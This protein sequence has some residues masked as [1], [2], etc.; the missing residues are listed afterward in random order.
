[1]A[2]DEAVDGK[3]RKDQ[4]LEA[5]EA[6]TPPGGSAGAQVFL[7]DSV[8]AE[9]LGAEVK[10]IVDKATAVSAA[11]SPPEIGKIHPRARSFSIRAAPSVLREIS[12]QR[13]VKAVLPSE[14]EE[15]V[16]IEPIKKT[17]VP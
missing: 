9:E 12:G 11:A 6:A 5:L 1:M 8:P 13:Q 3:W 2:G 4:V 17:P 10:R 7:D 15:G 14:I 16:S